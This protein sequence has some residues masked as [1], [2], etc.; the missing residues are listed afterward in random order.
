M[1]ISFNV[2][3]PVIAVVWA[4][5]I[6][7]F[8]LTQAAP[9]LPQP[10]YLNP[11]YWDFRKYRFWAPALAL[12]PVF[13]LFLNYPRNAYG[14]RLRVQLFVAAIIVS[15]L[16]ALICYLRI[17]GLYQSTCTPYPALF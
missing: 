8:F 12:L 10:L 1:R 4:A 14:E 15:G 6:G 5:F 9:C 3:L 7:W 2:L 11:E 13:Y 16:A 17:Q